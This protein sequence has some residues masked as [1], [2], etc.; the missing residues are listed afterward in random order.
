[1]TTYN[2]NDRQHMR[3]RLRRW[4]RLINAMLMLAITLAILVATHAQ[5]A[6]APLCPGGDWTPY[7]CG[8]VV[9][10]RSAVWP[11]VWPVGGRTAVSI[12]PEAQP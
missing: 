10:G 4:Q 12:D 1:M 3:Y 8:Y 7:G 6:A 5:A 11:V 2:R 9:R